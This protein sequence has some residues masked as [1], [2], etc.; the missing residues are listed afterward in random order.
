MGPWPLA[1]RHALLLFHPVSPVCAELCGNIVG[2][3]FLGTSETTLPVKCIK[4]GR[5]PGYKLGVDS[6][7]E[8]Y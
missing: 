8:F 5:L 1:A 3:A 4:L 6:S 2:Q 7:L